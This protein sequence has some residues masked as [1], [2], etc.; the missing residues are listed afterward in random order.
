MAAQL[1]G[2]FQIEDLGNHGKQAVTKLHCLLASGASTNADPKRDGFYEIEG[3]SAVY[4][5]HVTPESRKVLLLATWQN[6]NIPAG[7]AA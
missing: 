3:D 7:D 2:P 5:V 6:E 4:Y 1:R